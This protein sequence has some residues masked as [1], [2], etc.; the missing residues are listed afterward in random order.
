M[1]ASGM[2]AIVGGY[3]G[4][5]F[6]VLGPHP[7]NIDK[8]K[9]LW[10]IRAFLPQAKSASVVMGG[11]TIPMEK[12][13]KE[14]FY[15]AELS[16]E[17]GAYKFHIEDWHGGSAA[18]DDP[19]RFG[20]IVTDFDLH[21]HSEGTLDEAW[22]SLGAH[23]AR[24]G[25]VD[26][27]R[28]AVWAPN[29]EFVSVAGDF[30]D[31]D[32]R[33]HPMRLR[34]AG[35][36]EIFIP[37]AR[38]GQ[39]YKYL[40]R[41]KFLGHQQLKSDPYGFRS[42]MPPKSASV[43][44]SIDD[45]Q[46]H[47]GEWMTRRAESDI[48]REPISIYEVH[49]ESWMRGPGGEWLTYNEL[50]VKLVEYVKRM[51]YTHIELLPIQ[52]YPFSGSW[53]Y[54]VIGYFAPTAR[55]GAP[56]EFMHFVDTC[57]REGIGVI[58]DWVP[59]HFPKDAHGL[60]FFDGTA[61]YEHSDPRQGEHVEWGTLVFNFGRNEIRQFLIAS[62]LFWLKQYHIDGLR[63]DAVASMLYLDY[64][65][66]EGE[67]IPNR[68]GGRENIE[69]IEFIKRFNQLAHAVP[70]AMT[71]AEE[72]T[73]FSGVS[74]PVY[75]NGLGFTIKWNMGWMH[76]MLRYFSVDPVY[77]K[78]HQNDITF[79]MLYAF[80][81]NF[82]LPISHDEVVYGK[83]S[84]LS[85][86]P[87]DEWQRFANAR[88]FLAYMYAHPGKKLAFMGCEIGDY[89]EWNYQV[90]LPW[91]VL[92]FP[93][94]A[95][96][97]FY[98]K[99]LNRIYREEPALYQVDFEYTGFEWID[100]TDWEQSVISFMRRGTH[101]SE[102]IVFACNFTPVPRLNYEIGVPEPGFFKEILNSDSEL[103][104]GSNMGNSGGVMA[105]RRERHNRPCNISIT[106]PPLA[107]VAFKKQSSGQG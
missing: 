99:E 6:S 60:A 40:V 43:V 106:L 36:W 63:V 69:A 94:H 100:F 92:Q 5:P 93:M 47:D 86:M 13:H 37:G 16:R 27:V 68:Y 67:W 19:Y 34:T 22:K 89:N 10:E 88:A 38:E 73:A 90:S 11:S 105:T 26:G 76:D 41:S 46:W 101:P 81:E 52:E 96:L 55:F 17:P 65:R 91:Q 42:E 25:N 80:S 31:W 44:C 23:L 28:F 4:D 83:R 56:K 20:I 1:N 77:R 72:S 70:G 35:V 30:N 62:A 24:P 33:R 9:T 85:K 2:E 64:S 45:Y 15:V 7:I 75:A 14:G 57:H 61:L 12:R 51:G 84:L 29:A 50:A 102:Y 53:G 103:F 107:V 39:S 32:T 98:V 104:G 58:M 97:Q 87:G 54:Q 59:A 79:S 78:Y 18:I 21:L 71:L 74:R 49:L 8:G 48:L 3:H 82:V 66:K 95:A